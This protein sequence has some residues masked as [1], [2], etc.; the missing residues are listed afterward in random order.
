[1]AVSVTAAAV[2]ALT[3]AQARSVVSA[4]S[5]APSIHNTQP[6]LWVT[7][8]G[9]LDLYA[10]PARHLA[11]A[12]PTGQQLLI[13]C[14][15]ALLHARLA[16][17]GLGLTAR[18]T[19]CPSGE[20]R[21]VAGDLPAA[22][23]RIVG[24]QPLR[25]DEQWLMDVMPARHTDR[26]PFS[27]RPIPE[28]VIDALR[29][30]AEREGAWL[31]ALDTTDQR[32][33]A[34]VLTARADWLETHDPAYQAELH[35]WTRTGDDAVDGIPRDLVAA[36]RE[37]RTGEFVMR[38]YDATNRTDGTGAPRTP[39]TPTDVERPTVLLIG[40]DTDTRRTRL[41]AGQALER[42]LLDATGR[43]LAA[44][45]LG[46]A[47]DVASTRALLANTVGG[48]GRV[49]MLIRI[50]YPLLGAAPLPATPR[51]DISEILTTHPST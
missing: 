6:W 5:S 20:A 35:R 39:V 40:T 33:D 4:A 45:P 38:D 17:R 26:R 21:V 3:E 1:M 12:D 11:V 46:Q 43:G 28:A 31:V 49:Q 2:V 15:A 7:A 32:I 14:G 50:G 23:I 9:G 18:V 8:G 16:I 41:M 48:L 44:S 30:D 42:V 51:R 24:A 25:E 10:D 27:S 34:A 29:L 22:S 19:L 47:I 36:S 37:T 13:S